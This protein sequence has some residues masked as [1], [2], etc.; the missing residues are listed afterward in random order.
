MNTQLATK[1][2]I[3]SLESLMKVLRPT[4]RVMDTEATT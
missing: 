4:T 1:C 3:D 2:S